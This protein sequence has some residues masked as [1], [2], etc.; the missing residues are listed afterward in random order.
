MDLFEEVKF[1]WEN[2]IINNW[3]TILSLKDSYPAWTIKTYDCYGVAIPYDGEDV[4]ED[5]SNATIHCEYIEDGGNKQKILALFSKTA[6]FDTAFANLCFDFINPGENGAFR[7]TLIANPVNWWTSWKELL[8]NVSIDE[9]VYDVLGELCVLKYYIEQGF[10]PEWDGPN[11]STYDLSTKDFFVEVKSSINRTK[12]EV[13]ISS[14]YQLSNLGK[15]LYLVFC[16][17]ELTHTKGELTYSINSVVEDLKA[18]GYN[19]AY[20]NELLEKKGFGIGKS[21]RKKQFRLHSMYRYTVDDAFPK[22]IE[23]SFKGDVL[24]KGIIDVSYTVDLSGLNVENLI[25]AN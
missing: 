25:E 17:F 12:K 22:V 20:I 13:T 1:N 8:G 6:S 3:Q 11:Q 10:T 24:P 4:R 5:F 14:I 21:A 18:L 16:V 23:Q 15:K 9:R 7:K 19:A 2:D